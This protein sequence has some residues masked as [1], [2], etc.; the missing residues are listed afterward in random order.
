MKFKNLK[1]G[2][3]LGVGFGTIILLA[4]ILGLVA[5][6]NLQVI[7]T[8]TE[9]LTEEF[10][11]QIEVTSK[12]E[13]SVKDIMYDMRGYAYSEN[14]DMYDEV[15][16]QFSVL[17]STVEDAE[18]LAKNSPNLIALKEK[19]TQTKE[20]IREYQK[21]ARQTEKVVTQI[22][23]H[24]KELDENGTAFVNN[25][26]KYTDSQDKVLTAELNKA[27]I[28][29]GA[30][31]NILGVLELVEEIN[32]MATSARINANKANIQKDAKLLESVA[33]TI[34]DMFPIVRELT[35][36]TNSDSQLELLNKVSE[37][38]KNYLSAV[39][40]LKDQFNELETLKTEREDHGNIVLADAES[41]NL[42]GITETIKIGN[43][44]LAS[45][46]FSTTIMLVGLVFVL[47]LGI[48]FGVIITKAITGPILKGV[49][50]AKTISNGDL[51]ANVDIEQDDEIGLLADALR[52]MKDRLTDIISNIKSGSNG[53]ASASQQLSSSAQQMSQGSTEQAA[54]AE[55]VSSAMEEMVANIQQNT[56][57]A[58]QTEKIA[59]K[60]SEDVLSGS[61]A[62]DETVR[63]MKSIAEKVSVI[64]EIARQT[65]LLALNAAVEAARAGEH[66]KGFAVVAAEVRKLAERSQSAATEINELSKRSVDV[67]DQSGKILINIVPDIQKTSDLVQ[68]I[69]ASS[70]EQNTGADQVNTAIQQLNSVI[71]QNA[72]VS[73][74]IAS[75]A[76]EL[77][78]Q[79][80]QLRDIISF[81]RV[82]GKHAGFNG[83]LANGNGSGK[84]IDQSHKIVTK[85]VAH[86]ASKSAGLHGGK[87]GKA[88]ENGYVLDLS[89][90]DSI[91]AE[92]EKYS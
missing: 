59:L 18:I 43:D 33:A 81:F 65:N 9:E 50:F 82:D 31:K 84:H 29:K 63:S 80:D 58:Q 54:S 55:E 12:I 92:Y 45:V 83:N 36:M 14:K 79:A 22:I 38:T 3:K 56:D 89:S 91:D 44:N 78:S 90:N 66:G 42:R 70:I 30:V 19:L 86:I 16:N 25:I 47:L 13:R 6:Y 64:G 48:M 41:I 76:E 23:V 40:T 88:T 20:N 39:E 85:K 7:G 77:S 68:E 10:L 72:S 69:S 62:V 53:I 2:S 67:A 5:V 8:E 15:T 46:N 26:V 51:T 17:E 4:V 61:K 74:E 27:V 28:D 87:K 75:S 49:D 24:R 1:L 11:P 60:A 52:T 37:S 35:K 21:F 57:N 71:Q 73:E 34:N 32:R